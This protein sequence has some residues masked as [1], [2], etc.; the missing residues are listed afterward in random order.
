MT[1]KA[2]TFEV[3]L[4]VAYNRLRKVDRAIGDTCCNR[5]LHFANE[6]ASEW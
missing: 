5:S 1:L 3:N 4:N 6:A 2:S